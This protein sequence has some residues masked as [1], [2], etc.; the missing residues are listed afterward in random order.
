M[1]NFLRKGKRIQRRKDLKEVKHR[2]KDFYNILS[3]LDRVAEILKEDKEVN[4]DNFVEKASALTDRKL[5]NLE[6]FILKGKLGFYESM[7]EHPKEKM[8][9]EENERIQKS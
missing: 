5:E 6:Q 7:E 8:R 4:I 3:E 2:T 9:R 1:S